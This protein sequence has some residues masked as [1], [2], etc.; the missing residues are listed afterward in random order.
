MK[1]SKPMEEGRG[2]A[3]PFGF[4]FVFA[5]KHDERIPLSHFISE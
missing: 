2:V 4:E 5:A 1:K 3:Q